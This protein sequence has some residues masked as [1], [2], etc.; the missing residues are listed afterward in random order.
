VGVFGGI[1]VGV[2]PGLGATMGV[3]VLLPMT[4]GMEPAAALIM[5]SAIFTAAIY[6]GCITS[7]LLHT[8]GTPANAASAI[9]GY[10]LTLKGQGLRAVGAATVG[11]MIGGT[12]SAVM[13][14]FLAPPLARASLVFSAPEFFLIALFGLTIIGSLAGDNMIKGLL[15]GLFGLAIGII[16]FDQIYGVR[17]FTYGITALEAGISLVPALIGPFSVSQVLILAEGLG[18]KGGATPV[19][20]DSEFRGRL[21]PTMPEFIT[22]I[23]NVI[24]SSVIGLLVGILPG[25]GADI[26]GWLGYNEAKRFSK[27]RE[28]FGKGAIEG[29]WAAETANN[30]VV[31]GSLVP[32]MTLG[33]PGS[34]AAAVLLGGMLLHGLIP[35]HGLFTTQADIAYAIIFGFL[36]ANILMGIVGLLTARYLVKV[37]SAP[38]SVLAPSIIVLSV[39]GSYAINISLVD[40]S[41]MA[42]FGIIGYFMRKT[43]F[44]T[45]P[46]V[47]AMILGSIAENGYKRAVLMARGENL[48][49]FYMGRPVSV[50][51]IALIVFSL[52][53]PLIMSLLQKKMVAR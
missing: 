15:S 20:V 1:F 10:Q 23:P 34:S 28:E 42:V 12:F 51:L 2:V 18:K 32:T 4:F 50:V 46:V 16:G 39:I 35:G 53:A 47:L 27:N 48:L 30:A 7:I 22:Q 31:G 36:I 9:D 40:V 29:V 43:G 21:M 13:L 26:G 44:A 25:P 24:R 11:S 3:A 37:A 52:F 6:G 5:L 14:L 49:T 45:A 19:T 41:V 38:T 17:R 33:I 8:P